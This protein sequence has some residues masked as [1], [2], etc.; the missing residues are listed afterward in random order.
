MSSFLTDSQKCSLFLRLFHWG[1]FEYLIA[2]GTIQKNDWNILNSEYKR[3]FWISHQ[4]CSQYKSESN[5]K[6][7]SGFIQTNEH[8]SLMYVSISGFLQKS[9]D[10]PP[11][12]PHIIVISYVSFVCL[13]VKSGW[14][15]STQ[16]ESGK[17]GSIKCNSRR[18]CDVHSIFR[19]QCVIKVSW[20]G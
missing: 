9:Q 7:R 14:E 2:N 8:W 1:S 17:L 20:K 6:Q 13:F 5:V 4:V 11:D 10:F 15:S 3:M 12:R 18:I 16:R 19:G